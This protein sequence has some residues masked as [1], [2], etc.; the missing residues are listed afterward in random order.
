MN[1]ISFSCH[2]SYSNF[3]YV[4]F[5]DL[6]SSFIKAYFEYIY[7]E[8]NN[9]SVMIELINLICLN[10]ADLLA[11]FFVLYTHINSKSDKENN[12]ARRTSS[13]QIKLIYNDLSI[14]KNKYLLIFLISVLELVGRSTDLFYY[15]YFDS[16]RIR[17]GEIS[18]LI[19]IDILSRIIFSKIIL[20]S[21]LYNHHILSIIMTVIGLCSM[22]ISAF[23]AINSYE[24][25]RW[26][27]FSFIFLKFITIPLEDVINKIL[28]TNKFLLPQSLMFMRGLY[29]LIMLLIIIPILYFTNE[30]KLDF[31]F[32]ENEIGYVIQI[33]LLIFFIAFTLL[34]SF[35][36]MKVI[37]IFTPQHVAFLNVV[38]YMIRLLRCRITTGDQSLIIISD[39]VF[40]IIIIFS[41]LLFN[42]MIVINICG[43]NDNT[44][45]GFLIKEKK[46]FNDT[47]DSSK[48]LESEDI[49]KS[50]DNTN[51]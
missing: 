25:S 28:L 30:L 34:K 17:D 15:I 29:N 32:N 47:T 27:Y 31:Y 41:T 43:L 35:Y 7:S 51:I 26:P 46:E 5:F 37:Y 10:I 40:L 48:F 16:I 8:I 1:F 3:F 11:G 23:I 6:S 2:K 49:D 33:S 39:S 13:N 4:W 24:L 18:W 36:I 50:Q 21:R 42:E 20:K 22:S 12:E 38:F 19:S 45:D 14:K 9:F 44:K